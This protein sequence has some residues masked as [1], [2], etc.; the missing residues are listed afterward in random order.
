VLAPLIA[1]G[2]IVRR[3]RVVALEE[4]L[5]ADRRAVRRLRRVRDRYGPGPVSLALPGRSVA[6]VLAPGDVA[7]ILEE[8]PQP[9]AAASREKRA[10]L[11]H[12]EP[13]GVLISDPPERGARRGF[14]E[15]VLESS[16][17][18]HG[19]AHELVPKVRQEA[20]EILAAAH[21]SGALSWR[22]FAAGWWRAARRIVLGDGAR[23]DDVLTNLLTSL[24]RDANWA[25][26]K[27][28]RTGLRERFVE[29]LA[30]HLQ[31]A[32]PGSL[33]ELA[34]TRPEGVDPGG[35]VPQWLFAFDAAGMASF[36]TLAL[37][38]AHPHGHDR[39]A[40]YLRAS[41][42]EALRLWPTTPAVLRDTTAGTAWA[43]GTLRA[44]TGI[45]I[46]T[47]FF[48]RDPEA[49]PYADS[50]APELC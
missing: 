21:R 36:R 9:F 41:V 3:P 50:F 47:P 14:N 24:R 1:R 11:A 42:L 6:M 13:H 8:T 4:R 43:N 31:R 12:F 46:F 29:R 15:R 33:A 39:D 48:H 2:V 19:L 34:A 38:D 22:E 40:A 49:L 25:F 26:L 28:R 45:V 27:P 32:E 44:R 18:V 20:E 7:R 5:D 23:D 35:Q 37:L 16:R 10:A 30:G 17:P